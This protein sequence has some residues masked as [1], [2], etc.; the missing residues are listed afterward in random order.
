MLQKQSL[1][2]Q[3][4]FQPVQTGFVYIALPFRVW[5]NYFIFN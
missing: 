1:P 2:A 4:S 3:T 5:G